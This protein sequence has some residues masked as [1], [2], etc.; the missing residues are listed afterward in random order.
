MEFPASDL[1]EFPSSQFLNLV[2]QHYNF[3]IFFDFID[4]KRII[5]FTLIINYWK[6]AKLKEYFLK[7][8]FDL[9]EIPSSHLLEIPLKLDGISLSLVLA[10]DYMKGCV[11]IHLRRVKISFLSISF[12]TMHFV[13]ELKEI[14]DFPQP[15]SKTKKQQRHE[16][17][18]ISELKAFF[19][20]RTTIS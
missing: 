8:V 2:L 15:P 18:S 17:E 3:Y 16:W 7:E 20:F 4:L 1:R 10:G 9:R 14:V 19:C 13:V 12:S 11:H 6:Q 5:L